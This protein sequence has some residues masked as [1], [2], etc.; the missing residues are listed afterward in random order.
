MNY[1][2]MIEHSSGNKT[3]SLDFKSNLLKTFD[4]TLVI[5]TPLSL[6]S[7]VHIITLADISVSVL[8]P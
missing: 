7:L 4:Y 2:E 8:N 3:R 5:F 1:L 6:I